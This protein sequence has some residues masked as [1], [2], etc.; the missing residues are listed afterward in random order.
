MTL[1]AEIVGKLRQ[2]R[3]SHESSSGFRESGQ[4]TTLATHD[5]R[6]LESQ[7]QDEATEWETCDGRGVG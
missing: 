2:T 4:G 6:E 5:K 1:C 7:I 3:Q